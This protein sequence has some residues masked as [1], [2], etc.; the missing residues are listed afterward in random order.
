[1]QVD[2]VFVDI[3]EVGVIYKTGNPEDLATSD[4]IWASLI[5]SVGIYGMHPE[6]YPDASLI[7]KANDLAIVTG[8]NDHFKAIFVHLSKA[9]DY[10][11]LK[12]DAT[13]TLFQR[14]GLC[15]YDHIFLFN[16]FG[17]VVITCPSGS[18]RCLGFYIKDVDGINLDFYIDKRY[19]P[20]A[21]KYEKKILTRVYDN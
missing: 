9:L 19:K 7:R 13:K 4:R 11:H 2:L 12:L 14:F 8:T 10:I 17:K 20:N 1:M 5:G 6:C 18:V 16:E 3:S 21:V 15:N